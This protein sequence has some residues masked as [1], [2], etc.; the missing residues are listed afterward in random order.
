MCNNVMEAHT[1]VLTM[2][3]TQDEYH[4]RLSIPEKVVNPSVVGD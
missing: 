3:I 4:P 2:H 1:R